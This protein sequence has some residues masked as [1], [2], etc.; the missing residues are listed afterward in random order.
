MFCFEFQINSRAVAGGLGRHT[1]QEIAKIGQ[2]D[3]TAISKFLGH[4]SFMLGEQP[5]LVR[6]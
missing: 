2:D 5:R 3:I 1:P 4:K 6:K